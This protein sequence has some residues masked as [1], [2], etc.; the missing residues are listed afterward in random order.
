[1]FSNLKKY[2][3]T[4]KGRRFIMK[5]RMVEDFLNR[6]SSLMGMYNWTKKDLARVSGIKRKRLDKYFSR[7]KMLSFKAMCKIAVALSMDLNLLISV[8]H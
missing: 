7:E 4:S 6:A 8:S 1:M 3:K 5:E 2:A